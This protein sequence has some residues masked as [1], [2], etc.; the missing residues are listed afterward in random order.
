MSTANP[1]REAAGKVF[2]L[3]SG[4]LGAVLLVMHFVINYGIWGL[5]FPFALWRF[6]AYMT[7]LSNIGIV[8]VFFAA[9]L[10]GLGFLS[11]FRRPI[12]RAALAGYILL[13]AIYYH[14]FILPS[15]DLGGARIWPELGLHYLMTALYI[16]WLLIF[17]G[18][19]AVPF[20]SVFVLLI[21]PALYFALVLGR[22]ALV[23]DY[24]YD[25]VD[26]NA[27]G[28][29]GVA[30]N[31]FIFVFIFLAFNALGIALSRVAVPKPA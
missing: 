25:I 6:F 26:V 28:Y 18:R 9:G 11:W 1:R 17:A 13:V 8:L 5:S 20:R 21:P 16:A 3:V 7:I 24:P 4:L 22:G 30:L 23:G 15:A 10:P 29:G 27:L 19:A 12:V 14:L 2:A 31:A